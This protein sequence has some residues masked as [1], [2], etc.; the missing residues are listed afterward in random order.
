M[1]I[2]D[3]WKNI[4]TTKKELEEE[5]SY[6]PYMITRFVSMVGP[7]MTLAVETNLYDIPK[8]V[9][10]EFYRCS[11]PQRFIKIDYLKKK[12][13]DVDNSILSKYFE[14]GSRDQA[15]AEKILN[16]KDIQ[17]IKR[18]YGGF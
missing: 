8:E 17:K 6:Q 9:H 10:Y 7:M 4:T 12:S 14:F 16:E 18:K 3:H 13:D 1:T 11:L 15:L 2:F 5:S